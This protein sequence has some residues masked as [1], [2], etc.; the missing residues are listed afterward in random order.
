MRWD[1]HELAKKE[2]GYSK[3]KTPMFH[4]NTMELSSGSGNGCSSQHPA[5]LPRPKSR[6]VALLLCSNML[7]QGGFRKG[8]PVDDVVGH[9]ARHLDHDEGASARASTH[10][11]MHLHSDHRPFSRKPTHPALGDFGDGGRGVG[12]D[13]KVCVPC[14]SVG[15]RR[16][17]R[18]ARAQDGDQV[19]PARRARKPAQQGDLRSHNSKWSA[20]HNTTQARPARH[21]QSQ[22]KRSTLRE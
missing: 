21:P 22:G 6:S 11:S 10:V 19:I 7:L 12:R 5:L 20:G 13:G 4:Q 14:L 2:R 3:T 16:Q 9:R 1:G 18:A 17:R 8:K 15:E